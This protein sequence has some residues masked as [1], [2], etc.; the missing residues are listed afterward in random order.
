MIESRN[1]ELV[2]VFLRSKDKEKWEPIER[3]NIPDWLHDESII[4]RMVAG[5]AVRNTVED[6]ENKSMYWYA[7]TAINPKNVPKRAPSSLIL[8]RGI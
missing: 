5:E 1:V 8:P 4:D 2:M 6:A 3:E 7:V